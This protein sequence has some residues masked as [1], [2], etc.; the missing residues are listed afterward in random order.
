MLKDIAKLFT[1]FIYITGKI[2]VRMLP[3]SLSGEKKKKNQNYE[4]ELFQLR[5]VKTDYTRTM[6]EESVPKK[7]PLGCSFLLWIFTSLLE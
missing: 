1:S 3:V 5:V 7:P 6:S 2:S 4:L